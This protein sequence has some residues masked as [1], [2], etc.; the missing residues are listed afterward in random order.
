MQEA[1]VACR[2]SRSRPVRPPS[3]EAQTALNKAAGWDYRR[4]T[5]YKEGAVSAQQNDT[6]RAEP[7]RTPAKTSLAA[8][9]QIVQE[10][11][12][13]KSP[14][15]PNCKPAKR[16]ATAASG[17][18]WKLTFGAKRDGARNLTKSKLA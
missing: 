13:I 18:S 16:Y 14:P 17:K 6:V 12:R 5:L 15:K 11:S 3:P 2:G 8:S 9:T 10:F 1:G 4:Y 7:M